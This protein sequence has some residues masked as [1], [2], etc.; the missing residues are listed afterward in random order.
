MN[1]NLA[2][3]QEGRRVI[4]IHTK[5]EEQELLIQNGAWTSQQPKAHEGEV[6][7]LKLWFSS[8]LEV[9]LQPTVLSKL[10]GGCL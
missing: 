8:C 1:P 10:F 2:L 4:D 5:Y 6:L 7:W 3:V 9:S